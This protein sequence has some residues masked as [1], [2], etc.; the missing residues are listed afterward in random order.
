MTPVSQQ[1]HRQWSDSSTGQGEI[2]KLKGHN[3]L[4]PPLQ[5]WTEFPE[6]PHSQF[7]SLSKINYK[8][9]I[10]KHLLLC[11]F[12]QIHINMSTTIQVSS[13]SVL[14]EREAKR[15][16]IYERDRER[17]RE[18]ERERGGRERKREPYWVICEVNRNV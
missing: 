13:C 8:I 18:R 16:Y 14:Y 12:F 10:R 1:C 5:V 4:K 15:S 9:L 17:E 6:F 7:L 3:Q 2:Q 11:F